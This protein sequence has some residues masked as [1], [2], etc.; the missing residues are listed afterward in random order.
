MLLFHNNLE[1]QVFR[2]LVLFS[3]C[4]LFK[5]EY[6]YCTGIG[7]NSFPL[8]KSITDMSIR[9]CYHIVASRKWAKFGVNYPF[10]VNTF[11]SSHNERVSGCLRQGWSQILSDGDAEKTNTLK[12][13]FAALNKR[14]WT[15]ALIAAHDPSFEHVFPENRFQS[16]V[17]FFWTNITH[18]DCL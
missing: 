1:C 10:D 8:W 18:S 6:F 2:T 12:W 5:F 15:A 14:F 3:L 9:K 16:V 4:R 7:W 11:H 17:F 13:E